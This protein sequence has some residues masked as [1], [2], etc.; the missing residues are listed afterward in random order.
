[1]R[2]KSEGCDITDPKA[3]LDFSDHADMRSRGR[4][5]NLVFDRSDRTGAAASKHSLRSYFGY[6]VPD[7]DKFYDL[8]F[9]GDWAKAARAFSILEE[10]KVS[11]E[12]RVTDL[13]PIGHVDSIKLAQD[14]VLIIE[15]SARLLSMLMEAFVA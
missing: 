11:F 13:K 6:S 8:P 9:P 14:D 15:E 12:K 3:L 1:M 4:A 5:K 10:L 2:Y 7:P